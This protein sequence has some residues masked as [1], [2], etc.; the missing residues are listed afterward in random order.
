MTAIIK[1]SITHLN[2]EVKDLKQRA[3]GEADAGSRQSQ[4]HSKGVI[5][6][7]QS[8]LKK[9]TADFMTVVKQ[10]RQNVADQEER[11]SQFGASSVPRE[12]FHRPFFPPTAIG[13]IPAESHRATAERSATL[14]KRC[15]SQC[16]RTSSPP[17]LRRAAASAKAALTAPAASATP[18]NRRTSSYLCSH[19]TTSNS[20]RMTWSRWS[21]RSVSWVASSA[22]WP[23]SWRSRTRWYTGT[24]VF[25]RSSLP[26]QRC[27]KHEHTTQLQLRCL[28][29]RCCVRLQD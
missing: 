16:A 6:S 28:T 8:T 5:S 13:S 10:R 2:T 26:H 11:K 24:P 27:Y 7:L 25:I 14:A 12:R 19:R 15:S 22:S 18:S 29:R 20:V 21:R 9:T 17:R 3:A 4:Q 23:T 1:Q